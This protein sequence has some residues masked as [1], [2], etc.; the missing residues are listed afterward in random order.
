MNHYAFPIQDPDWGHLTI[1]VC[2]H[3]PFNVPMTRNGPKSVARQALREKIGFTKE[4][5]CFTDSAN[6]VDLDRVAETLRSSG[7]IG[8]LREVCER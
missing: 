3:P 6:L 5:N 8:P 1:K 4:G 2:P 7:A